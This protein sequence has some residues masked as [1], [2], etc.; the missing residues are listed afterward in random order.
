MSSHQATINVYTGTLS[1]AQLSNVKALLSDKGLLSLPDFKK[2]EFSRG[3]NYLESASLRFYQENRP[4]DVGY[5]IWRGLR[6][7]D[8]IEGASEEVK[9]E[10]YK[11]KTAIVP[12]IQWQKSLTGKSVDITKSKY[13]G[14]N[15]E[16]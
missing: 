9:N 11:A 1:E 12:F 2:P 4:K 3:S 13:K 8:S 5:F 14:C 6:P 7:E 16:S 15:Y 10:Q